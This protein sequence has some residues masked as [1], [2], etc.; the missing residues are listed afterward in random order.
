MSSPI[1]S[2]V[3]DILLS[4]RSC[5]SGPSF[6]NFTALIVGW[7][8]CQGRHSISRVIQAA[9]DLTDGKDHSIFYRF[10][11]RAKWTADA[12]GKVLFK[13]FLP[14]VGKEVLAIVDDTHA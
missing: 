9:G 2:T 7:I 8:L 6:F 13:L 10:F 1:P 12:V 4:F 5:F 14:L 3:L 11:S